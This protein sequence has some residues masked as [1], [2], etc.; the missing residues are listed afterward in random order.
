MPHFY[1]CS[2]DLLPRYTQSICTCFRD[3]NNISFC[4]T[5]VI[6]AK[7]LALRERA[8]RLEPSPDAAPTAAFVWCHSE[9]GENTM[10]TEM[11][12]VPQ[13]SLPTEPLL[14]L[15]WYKKEKLSCLILGTQDD[16]AKLST[17]ST[18]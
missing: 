11:T 9:S 17:S 14:T 3:K 13:R 4:F 5:P 12:Q 16:F 10:M 2:V 1:F 7:P 15:M 6:P 18:F 8:S